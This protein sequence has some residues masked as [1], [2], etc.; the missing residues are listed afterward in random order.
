M[1]LKAI[2]IVFTCLVLGAAAAQAAIIDLVSN[3][4]FETGD[5]TGWTNTGT[6]NGLGWAIN[7]G[8]FDPAGP[9]VALAP[10]G[11]NFRCGQLSDGGRPEHSRPAEHLF[12]E[13][14]VGG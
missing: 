13:Q 10:I 8:T 11:G 4:N 6:G 1:R 12:P 5:F 3:G 2:F 7:D 9:G 14:R